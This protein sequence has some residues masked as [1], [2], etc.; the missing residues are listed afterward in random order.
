MNSSSDASMKDVAR[1]A[2]VSTA[3]VS[4]V[5]NGNPGVSVRTQKK[6]AEAINVLSYQVNPTARKLRNGR[7][8]IVGF[9]VSNLS[10]YFYIEIGNA[11]VNVLNQAGYHLFY[12][13][14]EESEEKEA[15]HIQN[16]VRENF[17]G[18]IIVPVAKQWQDLASLLEDIPCVFLDRKPKGVRRD[19][20][21]STNNNGAF[22]GTQKLV[23]LGARKLAFLS[24]RFDA[25]MRERVEGFED[26]IVQN[27]LEVDHEC[28]IFGVEHPKTFGEMLQG[29]DWDESLTYVLQKKRVDGIFSGNEIFAFT[30]INYFNRNHLITGRDLLFATFDASFWM[31][32]VQMPFLAVKQDEK[33][34]GTVAAKTLLRRMNGEIFLTSEYRIHTKLVLVGNKGD[35][36]HV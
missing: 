1:L 6:V 30:A 24:P 33:A 29:G 8:N 14:S 22:L 12:M 16:C 7:S 18:I 3:T 2:G 31:F 25:T 34:L 21:L 27:G 4:H 17:A 11:I 9:L 28:E 10:N 23:E 5:I 35:E 13:N 32:G 26:A 15:L 36:Q 20:V 19:T